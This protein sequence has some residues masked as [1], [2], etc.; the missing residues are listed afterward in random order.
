MENEKFDDKRF[1]ELKDITPAFDYCK[2]CVENDA[3]DVNA[4]LR[5]GECYYCGVGTEVNEKE[6]RKIFKRVIKLDRT[7]KVAK[8][9]IEKFCGKE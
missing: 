7:N 6:A 8:N 9:I 4:L 5:L 1:N 3:N 2:K